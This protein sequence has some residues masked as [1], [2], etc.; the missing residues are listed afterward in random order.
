MSTSTL[1]LQALAT[2]I[3]V[4]PKGIVSETALFTHI[5]VNDASNGLLLKN[6][7]GSDVTI[8]TTHSAGTKEKGTVILDVND[9]RHSGI[10]RKLIT[11][12]ILEWVAN[13]PH[14]HHEHLYSVYQL[15]PRAVTS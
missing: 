9:P 11:H 7:V 13:E 6:A 4:T 5:G 14:T 15:N 2:P 3:H 12:N 1:Q 10:I 8:E